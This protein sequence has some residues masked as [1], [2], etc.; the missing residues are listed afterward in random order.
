V[1]EPHAPHCPAPAI[2]CLC[3]CTGFE[4]E[5][6]AQLRYEHHFGTPWEAADHHTQSDW[7]EDV[8]FGRWIARRE[9]D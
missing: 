1:T 7:M 8:I 2:G 4:T 6:L 5:R 3:D 9:P